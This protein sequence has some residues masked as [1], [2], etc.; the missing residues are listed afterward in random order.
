MQ[1]LSKEK[2]S[3]GEPRPCPVEAGA[4]AKRCEVLTHGAR[5]FV[6]HPTHGCCGNFN[7]ISYG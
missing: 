3:F 1:G 6:M 4:A 5:P 7:Y 2:N